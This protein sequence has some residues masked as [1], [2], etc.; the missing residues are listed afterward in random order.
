VAAALFVPGNGDILI[1]PASQGRHIAEAPLAFIALVAHTIR[2]QYSY[3]FQWMVG[4]LGWGD[5]PMPGWFY[6]AFGC[7]A[8]GCLLLE[9]GGSSGLGWRPRSLMIAAAACVLLIYAA[10]YALW[11][12]PG[13]S[14][15]IDGVEGRYFL[16]VAPLVIFAFPP[17]LRRSSR[18]FA[19]ALAGILAVLCAVTC[20]WAVMARYYGAAPGLPSTS[21]T[22]R[23]ASVSTRCA[24]GTKENILV[25]GIVVGGHGLERLLIRAIGSGLG[26]R[27]FSNAL[28]R[29]SL[30]VLNANGIVLARNTGWGTNPD[31]AQ[32]SAASAGAGAPALP[33]NSADS[34][35]IVNV[36]EGKYSVEIAGADGTTGIV[37]EE[38]HEISCSGTRLANVSSRGFVGTGDNV[39]T[40][41]LVVGGTGAESL[42]C[43]ADGPSLARFGV[44]GALARPTLELVQGHFG[45]L[46]NTGWA[47][48]PA[49]ADISAAASLVGA[50]PLDLAGADSAGLVSVP[51]GAYTMRI[52]GAG[53]SAGVALAEIYE[54][55]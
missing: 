31:A 11:N 34:A 21:G 12:P 7:G 27:G 24:V 19:P 42:L 41:G 13:S 49:R 14:E 17:M 47:S 23:L 55:P 48:S 10:Q 29:P 44:I 25:T 33:P 36:P 32:I 38:I 18:L 43:R 15:P 54:L 51:P 1:D 39:M 26:K 52:S 4:T 28:L 30:S 2:L 3:N 9:S 6:T 53:G 20:L 22:A 8:L 5:T 40:V 45:K 46:T 37:E 50:F 35:V 16:P